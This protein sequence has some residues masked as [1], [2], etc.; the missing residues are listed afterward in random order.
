MNVAVVRLAIVHNGRK[1]QD[2]LHLRAYSDKE[3]AFW[4]GTTCSQVGLRKDVQHTLFSAAYNASP[5]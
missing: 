2:R 3:A 4:F 1:C 5:A